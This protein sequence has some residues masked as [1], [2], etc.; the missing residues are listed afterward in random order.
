MSDPL[1]VDR[2]RRYWVVPVKVY[3]PGSRLLA[4]IGA[5]NF[6]PMC[7]HIHLAVDSKRRILAGDPVRREVL[8]FSPLGQRA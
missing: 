5:E 4:L 3:E 2:V 6:D 8:I 7:T 1:F